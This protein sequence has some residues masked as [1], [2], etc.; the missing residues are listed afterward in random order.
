MK[1]VVTAAYGVNT[2]THPESTHL[3]RM[4]GYTKKMNEENE[5]DYMMNT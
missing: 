5:G 2:E 3:T 4:P 1:H